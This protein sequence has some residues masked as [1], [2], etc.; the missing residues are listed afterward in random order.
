MLETILD[1]TRSVSLKPSSKLEAVFYLTHGALL[2]SGFVGVVEQSNGIPG[3]EPSLRGKQ[4]STF[5]FTCFYSSVTFMRMSSFTRF[6]QYVFL[7]CLI[8]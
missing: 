6:S 4:L 2:C 5:I 8:L 3:F 1:L 7:F